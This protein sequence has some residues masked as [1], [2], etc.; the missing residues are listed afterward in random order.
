MT[1]YAKVKDELVIAV[2]RSYPEGSESKL[3]EWGWLACS[4][5]TKVGWIYIEADGS[6]CPR[7]YPESLEIASMVEINKEPFPTEVMTNDPTK[8]VTSGI[9]EADFQM[10]KDFPDYK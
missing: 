2:M 5:A 10:F 8:F 4:D 6:F 3:L 9:V 7:R 1:L